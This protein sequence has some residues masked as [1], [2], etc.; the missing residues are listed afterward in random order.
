MQLNKKIVLV[1]MMGS[2]KSTIGYLLSKK[3]GLKFID[4]DHAIEK[5]TG[6]KIA[7]IFKFKGE[8]YF[9]KIEE[10]ITLKI[11]KSEN[12]IISL[13]GGSFLNANIRREALSKCITIWLNWS[14]ATILKRISKSK[15]RPMAFGVS[16]FEMS[17]MISSR[18]K[19]YS[20]IEFIDTSMSAWLSF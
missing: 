20:S 15:K 6:E 13:G 3:L 5:E 14:N 7:N 9:R 16:N 17:Q 12:H 4:T 10:K 18:S 11:L 8:D 19:I 1:G 2:G